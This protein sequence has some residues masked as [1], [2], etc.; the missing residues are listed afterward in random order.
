[1][2]PLCTVDEALVSL[3]RSPRRVVSLVPSYT[4]SLFD[5][6]LGDALVGISDYC[7]H[8]GD[9]LQ[10][11]PRVG[12]PMDFRV[13]TILALQPELILANQEENDREGILALAEAGALVWMSFPRSV[14]TMFEMLADMVRLF[15]SEEAAIKLRY[16]ES[17]FDWV[18]QAAA[19]HTRY[20]CPI[21]QES[22]AGR[23]AGWMTFNRETYSSDLLDRLGG[24]N[25]FSG[26]ERRY[27]PDADLG[28]ALAEETCGRDTRY[29]RVGVEEVVYAQPDL[30][31]LPDEPYVF[32][33]AAEEQLKVLLAET[34]AV[35]SDRV[36]RIEGRW[37]AWCGTAIGEAM[38]QLPW[39]LSGG[40]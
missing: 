19:T 1:M 31:L 5:L 7:T 2:S 13:D 33:Q 38:Q 9:A 26:R 4:Q 25:V 24:E 20:F 32:D 18:A 30:I 40:T 3:D 6:G 11:I 15:G 12:G 39:I 34:P 23:V 14:R 10:G 16:L 17:S 36:H 37:I 29:P 21:W 22:R 27:P 35:R 8:P 28:L